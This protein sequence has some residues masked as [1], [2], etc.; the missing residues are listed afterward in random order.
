MFGRVASR[1]F[2]FEWCVSFV[3][4]V[5]VGGVWLA[6]GLGLLVSGL[7]C[8]RG[9]ALFLNRFIVISAALRWFVGL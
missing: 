7:W 6:L 9:T 5:W 8:A 3:I 2:G 1:F 4:D